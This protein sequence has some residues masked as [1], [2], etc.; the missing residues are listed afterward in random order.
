MRPVPA[1]PGQRG[2]RTQAG[3]GVES[4]TRGLKPLSLPA[5]LLWAT[6]S[7]VTSG[8]PGLYTMMLSGGDSK[9][10]HGTS[11]HFALARTHSLHAH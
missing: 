6:G 3:A 2:F 10:A 8:L 11:S 4:E 9:N 1:A 5:P 7:P